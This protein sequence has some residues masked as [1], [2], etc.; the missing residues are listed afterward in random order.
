MILFIVLITSAI[1][2]YAFYN[3]ALID[4]FSLKPNLVYYRFHVHRVLTH[5]LVHADWTHLIINM[6][7]LYMFGQ[8]CMNYFAL[9]FGDKDNFY[10]LLLYLLSLIVSSLY[11]IC[12]HKKNPHYSA[13]GASGA[14]MAVVFTTIFFDPWNKLLFFGVIPVPG[15]VFGVLYLAY[16][17]YMGKK[18]SDNIGHDAHLTGAIFGFIYPIIINY[19]L[20]SHFLDKLLSR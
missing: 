6:I 16:S 1:S 14:V 15:I 19:Q 10:F 5:S 13:V 9:Y 3:H 8:V 12:K 20:Y 18:N 2:I 11:S 4:Q 7:V 17:I